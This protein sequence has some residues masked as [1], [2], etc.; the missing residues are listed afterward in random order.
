MQIGKFDT[1]KLTVAC[2]E[3]PVNAARALRP[4]LAANADRCE[5]ER[6]IVAPV[7]EALRNSGLFHITAPRRAGG[8][9][10]KLIT[11]IE[12]VAELARACPGTGWAYGLLSGI[13][14]TAL[15]LGPSMTELLF[16]HGGELFCSASAPSGNATG[17]PGGYLVSGRWG[18][19][20][21]CLH[22]DW[23]LNGIMLDTAV[24]AQPA[25]AFLDLHDPACSIEDNWHVAGMAGSGSNM[26]VAENVFVPEE[27]ILKPSDTP[28]PEVLLEMEG[29]EAR[30]RWPMEPLFPLGVLAPMLGAAMAMLEHVVEVMDRRP[31]VGWTF[32]TQTASEALIGM[33]G[34][35]A[36]EIDSAW[37]HVRQAAAMLDE[38]AQQRV[39]TGYD[40]ARIQAD[41]GYAMELLRGAGE[42]LMDVAGPG[43]F[44]L[45]NPL[46]RFWR[47]LSV[48]TRHNALNSHLSLELYGRAI[49]GRA[50]NIRLIPDIGPVP[51]LSN[52]R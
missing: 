46:Q 14:G 17:V 32:T 41:C 28:P 26:I 8:P 52:D 2:V 51:V 34:R 35:A 7:I 10:H 44:A 19:G 20:S 47:D 49:T 1:G 48:G 5:K 37:L 45:S 33:T 11:H 38:A 6:R 23:A 12:T 29:L 13:T 42:R 18:Y 24:G 40:K 3:N 25:M 27:L 39:L 9:G 21:G 36:M 22:A 31:V 50:S 16:R 15:G 43:A 30:D 4:L